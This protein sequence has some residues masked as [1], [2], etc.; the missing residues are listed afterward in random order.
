MDNELLQ[1]ALQIQHN[2]LINIKKNEK[3][4]AFTFIY[5]PSKVLYPVNEYMEKT[6]EVIEANLYIHIPYCTG[7]CTYCYFG[8]YSIG[9]A[10]VLEQQYVEKLCR[11]MELLNAK[12]GKVKILSI[13]FGGGTPT[14]LTNDQVDIVFA[15]IRECFTVKDGIEITMESSPETLT[16]SKLVCMIKNGVNRLNIGIQTLN[17]DLLKSINRRHDAN[18]ALQGIKSAKAIGINN[19]NVDV[20]YGLKGQTMEDW[21]YTLNTVL[22]M[23]LQSISTYRLRIHP[24]GKIKDDIEFFD[25]DKA[26]EMYIAMLD[27][28]N[29]YRFYQCSS[30]KFAIKEEMAQKQIINKRGIGKST[31]ISVGM[32]AYGNV[33]NIVY[34]NERTME[35]YV[36][37]IN[38]GDLPVSIGY[39][40]DKTEEMAKVCVLGIHN[41]NGINLVNFK[42]KFGVDIRDVY[43][44]LIDKL[45]KTDLIEISATNLKPSKLGMIFADE[46][47]TEFYSDK[48]KEKLDL[49][50]DKYGIFFD[51]ILD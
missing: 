16:E 4:Y 27:I 44:D 34:W 11:E 26:I 42:D 50:G 33:D 21:L 13:H 30:H 5:P 14:T 45:I 24:K 17:D 29:K 37:R 46:I 48:V 22:D 7:R 35:K 32:A 31:L 47:A 41:V 38:K 20:M 1:K 2:N 18:T 8:C 28:M 25:E 51:N 40:L 6:G 3:N 23:G 39:V 49:L 19:I 9:K 10:P 36:G 12:Y 43:G 15:K